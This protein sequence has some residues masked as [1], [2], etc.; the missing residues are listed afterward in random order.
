[1]NLN[2]AKGFLRKNLSELNDIIRKAEIAE[3]YYLC[4]NDILYA[5]KNDE[6]DSEPLRSA[7]NRIPSS[8]YPLLVNQKAAYTFSDPPIF[9]AGSAETDKAIS[10]VLGN[11]F[12]K[13]CKSLCVKASNC[14][15]AWIH[16]WQGNDGAF[17]YAVLD[18]IQAV[19]VYSDDLEQQL[20]YVI[21]V[22]R[23]QINGNLCDVYEIWNS[24]CCTAFYCNTD[25]EIEFGLQEYCVFG[26]NSGKTNVYAHCFKKPPFILFSNNEKKT[27]DLE[28]IKNLID[29]YDKTY[30]GFAND[31]EDIQEVIM[32]L[33]G[34]SGTDIT[35]FLTD[36]KKY[37]VIK[38]DDMSDRLGVD[39][40]SIEIP[41]E[42]RE[43][44]LEMTRK[45]IFEEGQGVDP[46]QTDFG[47]SSG[48]ALQFMYSLLELKAG[49]LETEFRCGFDELVH[50][51]CSYYGILISDIGQIWT[52]T[53]VRNDKELSEIAAESKGIISDETIIT[54]HPWVENPTNEMEKIEKAAV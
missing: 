30:S 42:A 40:L 54:R 38:L 50:E 33:S 25:S 22:Y 41:V 5:R 16:Y 24:K 18:G 6:K 11:R 48:V 17:K 8:F 14:G 47:N 32:I 39:T 36:L 45:A 31:L 52:R 23:R 19:G 2:E 29:I 12:A 7:D 44:M 13:N 3:R 46:R 35:E 51:I 4:E 37:K 15:Y 27:S 26:K 43:K 10:K 53:S 49:L 21:R 20:E 1:M 34:Y 28:C 9:T